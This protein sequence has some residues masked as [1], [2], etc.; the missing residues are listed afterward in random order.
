MLI[1]TRQAEQAARGGMV[2]SRAAFIPLSVV[3]ALDDLRPLSALLQMPWS[4]DD[5]LLPISL[6]ATALGERYSPPALTTQIAAAL[7][8]KRPKPIV[9]TPQDGFDDAMMDLWARAP[10]EFRK[11]LTFGLSF[12]PDDVQELSVVCTP[13]ELAARWAPS[14]FADALE[15]DTVC[16][17]AAILLDLPLDASVR[18]FARSVEL[19]LDSPTAIAI[20]LQAVNLWKSGEKPSDHIELLR[21]LAARAG[22]GTKATAVK[23]TVIERLVGSAQGWAEQDILLMRNLELTPIPSAVSVNQSLSNWI[24]TQDLTTISQGLADILISWAAERATPTWLS[25]VGQGFE[26]NFATENHGDSRFTLLW[27]VISKFPE[28]IKRF[29]SLIAGTAI[30]ETRMVTSMDRSIAAPLA[31]AILPEAISRGWWTLTGTLLARSRAAALALNDALEVA[32][33]NGA[34]KFKLVAS[35]LGEANDTEVVTIAV[36]SCDETAIQVAA[37][38]CLRTPAALFNFDWTDSAWFSLL[39]HAL[40]RSVGI[41]DALPDAI[42]GV[43]QSIAS[44]LTEKAVWRAISMCSLAD[45]IDVRGRSDAWAL[46]PQEYAESVKSRTAESWLSRFETGSVSANQLEPELA[47]AVRKKVYTRGYLVDVLR[48]TPAAMTRFLTNFTFE[49]DKE[50]VQFLED[51]QRSDLRLSEVAASTLGTIAFTNGWYETTR[52]AR[53]AFHLRKD[54]HPILKECLKLLQ[55]LDQLWITYQL[56]LPLLLSADEAWQAFEA[57]AVTMYPVGPRD[58]ELWSRSGGRNQDLVHEQT[59]KASWHRCVRD[60]RSGM[61]PNVGTLLH[62]MLED[63]SHSDTLRQLLKQKFW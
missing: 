51:V 1:H 55:Y 21:I 59:G 36:R 53:N 5:A 12:G 3:E 54:F 24:V 46:I 8:S 9:V 16:S 20:A 6:E 18:T 35:A 33:A 10:A 61:A 38:A 40:E 2:F 43:S 62:V 11:S 30:M 58:R 34:A 37:G 31:N 7:S 29:L 4:Q 57:E 14:A 25:T 49:S 50:A 17:H 23:T 13:T 48:R 47:L 39:G 45:L 41:V 52:T 15:Q 22:T 28:S 32:P 63:F 42:T 44:R 56:N 19:R 60:M 26:V 27:N